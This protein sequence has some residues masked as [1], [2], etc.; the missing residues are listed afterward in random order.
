MLSGNNRRFCGDC[1]NWKSGTEQCFFVDG[2]QV[3]RC[4]ANASPIHK[5]LVVWCNDA[6]P[7]TEFQAKGDDNE[8]QRFGNPPEDS[9]S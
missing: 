2:F 8:K 9:T 7:C 4:T 6:N 1:A 3:G 5:R